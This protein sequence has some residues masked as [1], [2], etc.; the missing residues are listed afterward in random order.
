MAKS[1]SEKKQETRDKILK[2]AYALF[3]EQGYDGTSYGEIA[4]RA[5]V[6]YGTIYFHFRTKENLLL[7]H[8]LELIYGQVA[9]LNKMIKRE[10]NPLKLALDMINMVWNENAAMPIR[11]LTVFFSYRWVSSKRDYDRALEALNAI[12]AIVGV[13]LQKAKDEGFLGKQVDVPLSLD[14]MRAAFL[15]ALQD[16]RFGKKERTEAKQR[17]DEQTAYLL[18]IGSPKT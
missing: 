8:Y 16:A 5:G 6:G 18:G 12:L 1:R 11:K 4:R 14:L 10:A 3:E 13:A 9:R 15:H 7:E 2:A 17:F